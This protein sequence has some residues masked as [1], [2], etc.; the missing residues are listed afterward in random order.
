MKYSL[1]IFDMDGTILNTLGDLAGSLNFALAESGYP[2]RS[3]DEVRAFVGNGIRKLIERGVP[4]GTDAEHTEKVLNDF[5]AHYKLHCS[6]MTRAYDG[7]IPLL[8]KLREQGVKTAVVSNKADFAVG[9]LCVQY[10]D[11]LF[12]SAVGEK[13]EILK[14]PAP[15][16]VNA[17]L[18][19]LGV[20]REKAVYVGDSE[21]DIETAA[22]AEMD[23]VIVDWG[24]R[25]A[26]FLRERG[27]DVIV[28][29]PEEL[30][31][32]LI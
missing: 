6:D 14:K 25:D 29:S 4:E 13:P 1:V 2:L 31:K 27:A 3:I 9:R 15:D 7:I 22:N 12:D 16:S 10:F 8:K 20:D 17:V 23:C 11:G 18:K 28:S 24:F 21:V 26:A 30:L 5:A 19:E 32:K